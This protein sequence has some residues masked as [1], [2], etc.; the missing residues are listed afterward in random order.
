MTASRTAKRLKIGSTAAPRRRSP[1]NVATPTVRPSRTWPRIHE[2]KTRPTIDTTASM[3]ARH[4]G[5]ID[6]SKALTSD[7]RSLSR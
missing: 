2:L 3:S 6:A 5:G 4:S 1:T 7:G